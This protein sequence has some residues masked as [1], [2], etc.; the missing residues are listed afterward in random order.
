MIAQ[1]YNARANMAFSSKFFLNYI[2]TGA[3][4]VFWYDM[5]QMS[6]V[7]QRSSTSCGW[8]SFRTLITLK[9]P[10]TTPILFETLFYCYY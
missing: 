1:S 9:L 10:I 6:P 8:G 4:A 2:P 5:N 3:Y 7:A